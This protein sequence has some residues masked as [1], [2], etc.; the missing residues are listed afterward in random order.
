MT[1]KISG[2]IL[3]T[4]PSDVSW[5][6]RPTLGIDGAGHPV[7]PAIRSAQLSWDIIDAASYGE[8]QGLYAAAGNTGTVPVTLPQYG[9][10][11]YQDYDYSGCVLHE[12]EYD[13]YFEQTYMGV[14]LL[15]ANIRG[16]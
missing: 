9:S 12:P 11:T 16:A 1:V 5:T 2:T 13:K 10:T 6:P 8:L 3:Q 7:Y 14:K 15:I 4:Q